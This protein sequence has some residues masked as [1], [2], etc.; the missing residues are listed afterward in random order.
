MFKFVGMIHIEY[1]GR[2]VIRDNQD[3]AAGVVVVKRDR[4]R[5]CKARVGAPR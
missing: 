5:K 3:S 1:V 2:V 4:I